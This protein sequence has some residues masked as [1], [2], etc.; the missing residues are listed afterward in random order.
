MTAA[1][2]L[3]TVDAA[4]YERLQAE[5]AAGRLDHARRL[6]AAAVDDGRIDAGRAMFWTRRIVQAGAPAEAALSKLTPV[7]TDA[8]AD[9]SAWIL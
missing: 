5:A 6:V 3:V 1:E 2:G 4:A 9:V 8:A 7:D